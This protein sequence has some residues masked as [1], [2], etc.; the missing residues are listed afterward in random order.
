MPQELAIVESQCADP[1]AASGLFDTLECV[2]CFMD[3][4]R[5]NNASETKV[6]IEASLALIADAVH[7]MIAH[8]AEGS[9]QYARF[10]TVLLN[11]RLNK[12]ADFK[13]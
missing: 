2:T 3:H 6:E 5:I 12:L 7:R 10:K 8:I 9:M 13:I 1:F 11:P 4:S